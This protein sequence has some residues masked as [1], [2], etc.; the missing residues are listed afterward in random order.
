VIN[1]NKKRFEIEI[2]ECKPANLV[3][4]RGALYTLSE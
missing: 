2:I 1:Y 3:T 4:N